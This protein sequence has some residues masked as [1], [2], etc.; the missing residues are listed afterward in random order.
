MNSERGY[1]LVEIMLVVT[2]IGV[3]AMVGPRLMVQLQNFY[4]Q[5]TARAE[6]QRD[7]R[8][9]VDVINRFLRQGKYRTII[10]D[11]PATQ[12]PYSRIRFTHVDGRNFEFSQ[13]GSKLLQ[14]VDGVTTTLSRNLMY[15]AFTFPRSDYPR[16]V[17]VSITMQKSTYK[18]EKRAL[19][20]TVQKIRV[21]N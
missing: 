12:G 13:S 4:L 8:S 3:I 20:L 5:T 15:L 2:I 11:S 16:L 17:S 6:I 9:T 21:M 7:A 19:E 18:G 14:K 1:S 10:I